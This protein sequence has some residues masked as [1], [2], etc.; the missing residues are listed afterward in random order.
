MKSESLVG[1]NSFTNDIYT[2]SP[3]IPLLNELSNWFKVVEG[4]SLKYLLGSIKWVSV[5]NVLKADKQKGSNSHQAMAKTRKR[6]KA[7]NAEKKNPYVSQCN[8]TSN[9]RAKECK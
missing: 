7:I 2:G 4:C 5:Q 9:D 3:V 8:C 6:I 1:S